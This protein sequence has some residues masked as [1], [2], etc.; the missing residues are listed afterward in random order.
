MYKNHARN[1]AKIAASKY[2]GN[3]QNPFVNRA[4]EGSKPENSN[5]IQELNKKYPLNENNKAYSINRPNSPGKSQARAYLAIY[6]QKD[7][8]K[9]LLL[10][11]LFPFSVRAL[12]VE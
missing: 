12:Q 11:K 5:N 6:F 10:K 8:S 9:A 1:I 2:E 4:N 7:V 3:F